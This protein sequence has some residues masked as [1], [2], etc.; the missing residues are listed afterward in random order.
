MTDTASM[1]RTR[2]RDVILT[3][4][5]RGFVRYLPPGGRMLVTDAARRGD[6]EAIASALQ[7]AGFVCEQEESGLMAISPGDALIAEITQGYMPG[8][9]AQI[10]WSSPDCGAHALADRLLRCGSLPLTDAGRRLI[11]EALRLCLTPERQRGE[12]LSALRARIAV[13]LR[14]GDRSGM[15]EA[16]WLLGAYYGILNDGR[17]CE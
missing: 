2:V 10:S 7:A 6:G 5:G 4:G 1:L 3:A 15:A 14:E 17:N 8:V 9:R 11:D 16:G 13:M 12:M